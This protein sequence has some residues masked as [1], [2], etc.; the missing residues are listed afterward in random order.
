MLSNAPPGAD[1]VDQL[2]V[3]DAVLP[4]VVGGRVAAVAD[5]KCLTCLLCGEEVGE[6]GRGGDGC[7]GFEAE[8]TEFC[9]GHCGRARETPRAYDDCTGTNDGDRFEEVEILENQ[10]DADD[11]S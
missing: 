9:D 11:G 8:E 6:E 5:A 7:A 2:W 3:F 4:A 1:V 10:G